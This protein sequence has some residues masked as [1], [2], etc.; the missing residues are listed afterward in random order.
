MTLRLQT[1]WISYMLNHHIINDVKK[2]PRR[3]TRCFWSHL[4]VNLWW[5]I[6]KATYIYTNTADVINISHTKLLPALEMQVSRK[7]HRSCFLVSG[8]T[9]SSMY[10]IGHSCG[11]LKVSNKQPHF[12][13]RFRACSDWAWGRSHLV[14]ALCI[15]KRFDLYAESSLY[16]GLPL[17]ASL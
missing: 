10:L 2:C 14:K 3:D 1:C 9:S 4:C 7:Q 11:R 13:A 12:S 5:Y 6:L 8:Q 15:I 16:R 17:H